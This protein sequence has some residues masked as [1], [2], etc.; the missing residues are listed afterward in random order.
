MNE[1]QKGRMSRAARI[2]LYAGVPVVAWRCVLAAV[3]VWG[4]ARSP[5]TPSGIRMNHKFKTGEVG[6]SCDACHEPNK[7][8][9]RLMS[10]PDHDTCVACHADAIDTKSKKKNCEP[11]HT[12]PDY[13]THVRK[14]RVLSPLVKF[15]HPSTRR[16][17]RTARSATR[18]STRTS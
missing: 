12:Q 11:C 16:R 10:F 17:A 13:A 1:Q 5:R 7:S 4:D 3:Y 14:D 9:P 15:D 2:A 8:N 6:L 18:F